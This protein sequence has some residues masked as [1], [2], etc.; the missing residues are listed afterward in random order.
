MFSFSIGILI[1]QYLQRVSSR[2]DVGSELVY[3]YGPQIPG[4]QVAILSLA[5]RVNGKQKI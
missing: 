3:Q 2:L 4:E 5:A 1:G